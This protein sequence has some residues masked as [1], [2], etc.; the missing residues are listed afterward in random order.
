MPK[1]TDLRRLVLRCSELWFVSWFR[2]RDPRPGR[3]PPRTGRQ[4]AARPPDGTAVQR[5]ARR[6]RLRSPRSS[7]AGADLAELAASAAPLVP[8]VQQ[9]SLHLSSD[10]IPRCVPDNIERAFVLD[11]FFILQFLSSEFLITWF[12]SGKNP[13]PAQPISRKAMDWGE[14][15]SAR[16][17]KLTFRGGCPRNPTRAF[18]LHCSDF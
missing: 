6:S 5:C 4:P 16:T 9:L 17:G 2:C 13:P 15:M 8:D 7:M 12:V 11:S 18:F 1:K 10:A 14:R 3:P